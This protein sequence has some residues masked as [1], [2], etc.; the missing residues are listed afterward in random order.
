VARTFNPD[1]T[2]QPAAS[3]GRSLSYR[4]KNMKPHPTNHYRI[5]I[6]DDNLAIH[7]DFRKV[8]VRSPKCLAEEEAAL[9]GDEPETFQWPVFEIDSAYQGKDG[10]D[11]IEKSLLEARPYALAFID[12]R[13]PPGWD[14]VETACEIWKRS[15]GLQIVICTAHSDYSWKRMLKLLGYSKQLFI[16][17]KPFDNIEVRQLTFA[18]TRQWGLDQQANLRLS[19][20]KELIQERTAALK[21]SNASYALA[22]IQLMEATEETQ[23]AEDHAT[24]N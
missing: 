6:I 3:L 13:M 18:M 5:L 2:A 23:N 8:L 1:S 9:F 12:V 17:K 10:L 11:L 22:T 20:L 21:T 19:D 16:L 15:P 7:D 4:E 24:G 14:G